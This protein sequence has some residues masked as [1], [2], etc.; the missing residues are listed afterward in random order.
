M[1]ILENNTYINIMNTLKQMKLTCVTYKNK[2]YELKKENDT[3]FMG[4]IELK[5]I[6]NSYF[7]PCSLR[8]GDAYLMIVFNK[9]PQADG[10]TEYIFRR[11]W[12]NK[13]ITKSDDDYTVVTELNEKVLGMGPK[14]VK[15]LEEGFEGRVDRTFDHSTIWIED[16]AI[17]SPE[18]KL[19]MPLD[20]VDVVFFERL[21]SY[22]RSFDLTM[23]MGTSQFSISAI[24][25]KKYLK[26][27]QEKLRRKEI[28]ETGPDPIPWD[29]MFKRKKQDGLS[30]KEL[31][32]II[33]ERESEEED[34]SD[35]SPG[36]TDEEEEEEDD[37]PDE[38][39]FDADELKD[40]IYEEESEEDS[41]EDYEDDNEDY[42]AWESKRK[43]DT[44][45]EGSNK[46][47]K[48]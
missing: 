26:F 32:D 7:S 44:D 47:T 25:R 21:T 34:V 18:A 30:W 17:L 40:D 36:N 5:D 10:K 43:R 27:I 20:K 33:T 14:G 31:H 29:A 9:A 46:K 42:D 2:Q 28:Y 13:P 37:Y 1:V 12:L 24:Q 35:W 45:T 3:L 23:V 6:K 38:E 15:V 4:D 16:S 11:N 39:E 8:V 22:T 48:L 19:Y 41:S